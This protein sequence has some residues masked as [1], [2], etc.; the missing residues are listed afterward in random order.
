MTEES[1][2]A[3]ADREMR[4]QT[5][6]RIRRKPAE[7]PSR[8]VRVKRSAQFI[9]LLHSS[10][11][12]VPSV[13]GEEIREKKIETSILISSYLLSVLQS[14]PCERLNWVVPRESPPVPLLDGS[15]VYGLES[16][17]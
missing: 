17:D 14:E 4:A 6:T 10:P 5:E 7:V 12:R 2:S 1:R 11:G 9:A 13:I 3:E 16:R 8:V 15:F